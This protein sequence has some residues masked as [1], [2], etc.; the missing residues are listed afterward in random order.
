MENHGV[1]CA[2]TVVV[3]LILFYPSILHETDVGQLKRVRYPDENDK[4]R[5]IK[6]FRHARRVIHRHS[7]SCKSVDQFHTC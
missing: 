4:Q 3:T 5:S 6:L 7:K 1:Q 2:K